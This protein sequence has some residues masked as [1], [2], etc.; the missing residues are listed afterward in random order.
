[1]IVET[2][3]ETI[4]ERESKSGRGIKPVVGLLLLALMFWIPWH[5]SV[6]P[7]VS[8]SYLFGF[9]NRAFEV[10][11]LLVALI[12]AFSQNYF[13][14]SLPQPISSPPVPRSVLFGV[15]A[16]VAGICTAMCL[17]T[18]GLSGYDESRYLI[19]RVRLLAE[20]QTPYQ[21]FEFAY[22]PLLLYGPLAIAKIFRVGIETGYDVFW[23]ISAFLG[24]CLLY[25]TINQIDFPCSRKR[26]IFLVFSLGTIVALLNT[27]SNYTLMRFMLPAFFAVCLHRSFQNG[28]S[29][30]GYLRSLL[31]ALLFTAAIGAVS[32][33]LG[34]A[35]ATG[36]LGFL[37]LYG[38]LSEPTRLA[39]FT[40]A[41][42]LLALFAYYCDRLRVF[43]TLKDFAGGGF[44]FPV[45]PAAHILFMVFCVIAST[46]I[47]VVHIRKSNA[48]NVITLL[49]ATALPSLP[50]AFGRCDEGHAVLCALGLPLAVSFVAAADARMWQWYRYPFFLI[51]ACYPFMVEA[52][53]A[54]MLS[55]LAIHQ[56]FAA[57]ATGG[58]ARLDGFIERGMSRALG[59]TKAKDKFALLKASAVLSATVDIH[60]LFPKA[61]GVIWVPF[62]FSPN[63][64]GLYHAREIDPGRY[65]GLL[66]VTSE[67]SVARK[68]NELTQKP[69]RQLLLPSDFEDQCL[70]NPIDEAKTIRTLFLLPY[71]AKP[72]HSESITRP[73]CSYIRAGYRREQGATP[74]TFGYELWSPLHPQRDIAMLSGHRSEQ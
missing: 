44:N 58:S 51:V 28:R 38:R 70:I 22:G 19:D 69:D 23:V 14:F 62:G 59:T 66:N 43:D 41:A 30:S 60:D 35:Y 13:A 21:D 72:V 64:F 9:S 61:H 50:A 53:A 17:L 16:A 26:T 3:S 49:I 34:I 54:P 5:I 40:T 39:A 65:D 2:I 29:F 12:I 67:K 20:G 15:L 52:N 27:G 1:M 37:A 68:I 57:E 8:D 56:I 42:A 45:I 7:A 18:H 71:H 74:E 4:S 10:L 47:A 24:Y 33:E 6:Q 11:L 32:P 25:E 63:R 31:L 36:A 46:S 73:F 48:P 55:K